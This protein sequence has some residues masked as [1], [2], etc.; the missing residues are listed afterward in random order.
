MKK[1]LSI[2]LTIYS[3]WVAL[4]LWIAVKPIGDGA[5]A[6]HLW[7]TVTGFPSAFLSWL[8]PHGSVIAVAAAGALGAAQLLAL[9]GFF[10][11]RR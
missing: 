6:A 4:W 5:V 8:L 10:A 11:A 7:L 3:V 9:V 1:R 2:A